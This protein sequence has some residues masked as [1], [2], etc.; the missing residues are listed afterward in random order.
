MYILYT[1]LL[2][3][4]VQHSRADKHTG[5]QLVIAN[6]YCSV[7]NQES[8]GVAGIIG[9]TKVHFLIQKTAR[10]CFIK[11]LFENLN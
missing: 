10:A 2:Q 5:E 11:L 4:M 1:N 3:N 6:L 8:P 7:H 9:V